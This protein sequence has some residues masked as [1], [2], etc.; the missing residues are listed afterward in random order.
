MVVEKLIYFVAIYFGL[1]TSVFFLLTYFENL[2]RLKNPEVKSYPKVSI[3]VSMYNAKGHLSKTMDSLLALNWPKNKLEI[4]IIDDGSI[5]DSYRSAKKYTADKRIMLLRQENKGKSIAINRALKLSTGEYFG[6]LDVDSFVTRDCLKKMM[7]YFDNKKVMAVTPSLKIYG[8]KTWLQRIQM[9][10][11]L[12]G[13]YLRKVFSYLGAVHVTPG[14]FSIYRKSFFDETGPYDEKNL[15][16]DIEIACRIQCKNY[17]IENAIDANVYTTGHKKIRQ[18]SNQRLRWYKGFIDNVVN[19][20]RIF[21]PK[22]GNLGMFVLPS[23]FISIV[24]AILLSGYMLF[25]LVQSFWNKFA[26]MRHTGFDISQYLKLNLDPFYI[27]LNDALL[28]G[29]LTLLLSLFVL[30]LVNRHSKENQPIVFSY[31]LFVLTYIFMYAFWWITAG[32]YRLSGKK[33][34][35]GNRYL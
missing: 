26:V 8:A 17:Q 21:H 16:E 19:Y 1:F 3:A 35:W 6:V 34:R 27:N 33:I 31:I 30:K 13:V 22:Y 25:S 24:L 32:Y 15:T 28:L 14:S 7:G 9:I 23:A 18:L 5:D 4:I 12:A 20:K 10:E 2:K 11:F 29:L